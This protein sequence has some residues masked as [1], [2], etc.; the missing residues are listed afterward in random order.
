MSDIVLHARHIAVDKT[1]SVSTL[2]TLTASGGG[3]GW[4]RDQRMVRVKRRSGGERCAP[5][6]AT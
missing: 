2:M 5:K 4:W 3:V 1:D 6:T